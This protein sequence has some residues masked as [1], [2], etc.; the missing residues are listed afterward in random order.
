MPAQR[1]NQTVEESVAAAYA[2]TAVAAEGRFPMK[3]VA[4]AIGVRAHVSWHIFAVPHPAQSSEH[5]NTV[6]YFC[7]P[8]L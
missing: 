6:T 5:P 7:L 3:T 2:L 8:M 1:S 4:E